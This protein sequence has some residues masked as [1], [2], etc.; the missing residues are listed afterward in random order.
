METKEKSLSGVGGASSSTQFEKS[1]SGVG[2]PSS[3]TATR[4]SSTTSSQMGGSLLQM[5]CPCD[6]STVYQHSAEVVGTGSFG[7]VYATRHKDFDTP[8]VMKTFQRCHMH[9]AMAEVYVLEKL[10]PHPHIVQLWDNWL[11]PKEQG[12]VVIEKWGTSLHNVLKGSLPLSGASELGKSLVSI[13][14][15]RQVARGV[16][17]ALH[18]VH[19]LGLL[20]GDV[21]PGNILVFGEHAKLCDWASALL[22]PCLSFICGRLSIPLTY[23]GR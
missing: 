10:N 12:Y 19:A 3:A 4:S 18:H 2:G 1:L 21:K 13:G 6:R 11:G 5:T 7:V 23:V 9:M 17:K 22:A 16:A 8:L 14:F 15:L 20:H